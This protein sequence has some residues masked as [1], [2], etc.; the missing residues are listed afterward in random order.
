MD[1]GI[2]VRLPETD[3]FIAWHRLAKYEAQHKLLARDIG[4][5]DLRLPDRV[6]VKVRQSDPEKKPQKGSRT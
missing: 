1:N 2:N 3:A 4:S 5:I 6:V